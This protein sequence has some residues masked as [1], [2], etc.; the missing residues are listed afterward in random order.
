MKHLTQGMDVQQRVLLLGLLPC[1]AATILLTSYF[2]YD[3]IRTLES[4]FAESGDAAAQRVSSYSDLSLYAGDTDALRRISQDAVLEAGID[5]VAI[6]NG[7]GVYISARRAGA[8]ARQTRTFSA[9]VRI[10][11][12][13][14]L[15][16]VSL[17]AGDAS[18]EVGTV[19]VVVDSSR[20]YHQEL[21]SA[22]TGLLLGLGTLLA[23][24][25]AARR[26]A[27]GIAVPLRRLGETVAL[28]RGGDLGARSRLRRDDEFGRLSVGIDDMAA[29]LAGHRKELETRVRLATHEAQERISQAEKANAAK[30]RFL[31]AASHDLRQPLHAVGLFVGKLRETA[32]A[33]QQPLVA[34]IDEGLAGMSGLLTALL[35]ISRLDA[36]V[37]E[38][39]RCVVTI[40]R[41]FGEAEAT[42][43]SLAVERRTRLLFR[44]RALHVDVD[45]ALCERI[46]C[47]L[48]ENALRYAA[49]TAV[50]V[51]ASRRGDRVR[52]EVRDGG[53]GIAPMYHERIFEEFFQLDNPERDRKKGLGLGLA[54]CQ[55]AARLLDTRIEL[56]SAIGR[57]SC[58]AFELPWAPPPA[59]AATPAAIAPR[60]QQ[61]RALVVDDDRTIREGTV[62]LLEQWGLSTASAGCADSAA[63]LL[64]SASPAFDYLLCD[65][66]LSEI[67]DG[68]RV[69]EAARRASAATRLLLISGDTAT[70]TLRR[71]REQGV[72]VLTKPVTPA[73]LR[74]ALGPV[75]VKPAATA[76]V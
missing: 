38:P 52:I 20:L 27:R 14:A 24:M 33:A 2:T 55:R 57:G 47:N 43:A 5:R 28:I 58:F 70:A 18:A 9:T 63:E 71:A 8:P 62:G 16:D 75:A 60:A 1:A 74:A 67:D 12:T 56:R 11:P 68:W 40:D 76:P 21:Q 69:I 44:R 49:G 19:H 22:V 59:V 39:Q 46:L 61:G 7:T 25:T 4:A 65:L 37:V 15:D 53:I 30:A 64:G 73:K 36:G 10:R 72:I 45:A 42:L 6:S 3:K 23:A 26:L 34:R 50:L 32:S 51:S 54:I 48:I 13:G 66:Q 29:A 35:D 31:A 41:L 17:D